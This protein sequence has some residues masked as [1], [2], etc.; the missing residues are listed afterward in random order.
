MPESLP[1]LQ[2]APPS[3]P[4]ATS[5]LD[6]S[7][8]SSL[9]DGQ[10]ETASD[11]SNDTPLRDGATD[12]VDTGVQA[13]VEQQDGNHH[14][15][16]ESPSSSDPPS[17]DAHHDET[18]SA[19]QPQPPE[20]VEQPG[21]S[22]THG[23]FD[24]VTHL[25]KAGV[26]ATV[27]AIVSLSPLGIPDSGA[28]A[29]PSV[30]ELSFPRIN[31]EAQGSVDNLASPTSIPLPLP[32]GDEAAALGIEPDTPVVESVPRPNDT[33]LQ[34]Q[35]TSIDEPEAALFD[36]DDTG[37]GFVPTSER[38]HT[39]VLPED[40]VT[41]PGSPTIPIGLALPPVPS[42]T[43]D[44]D[45][46]FKAT[47]GNA[48]PIDSGS[49][50]NGSRASRRRSAPEISLSMISTLLA[51]HEEKSQSPPVVVEL[52]H[53][54]SRSRPS[55]ARD[56]C[57][58]GPLFGSSQSNWEKDF[59]ADRRHRRSVGEPNLRSPSTISP[60]IP[61]QAAADTKHH[62]SML[63]PISETPPPS[64]AGLSECGIIPDTSARKT[65]P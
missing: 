62:V 17:A 19:S 35:Q 55:I 11:G 13:L 3:T 25:L 47:F 21:S 20:D 49:D 38:E 45:E 34:N 33:D 57:P 54:R 44:F 14:L 41:S 59:L 64:A 36:V 12:G 30:S 61:S 5:T 31:S 42:V 22:D 9:D 16:V 2:E 28:S 60:T 18:A 24:T 56:D 23:V 6:V 51:G 26:G 58:S 53:R 65:E 40:S 27:E 8:K 43:Y 15:E 29:V 63:S 37:L 52:K 1:E 7:P 4:A 50:S 46:I 48:T 10:D 32:D 39:R